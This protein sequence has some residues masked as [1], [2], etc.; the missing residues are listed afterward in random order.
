MT[1][2]VSL[3]IGGERWR[4]W[5][6]ISLQRSL[7]SFSTVT[8]TGPFDPS[9]SAMRAALRPFAFQDVTV[10]V[11]GAVVLT[12]TM[13]TPMPRGEP[14]ASSVEVSAY[15]RPAVIMDAHMPVDRFPVEW[16]GLHLAQI[17]REICDPY[18]IDLSF[19]GAPGPPFRRVKLAPD[20]APGRFLA[21][22]ARQ[23]GRVMRDTPSGSLLITESAQAGRPVA[24]LVEGEA[25]LLSAEVAFSPQD[26]FSAITGLARSKPGRL[27]AKHTQANPHLS[28]VVRPYTFATEDVD[29]GD[30]PGAVAAKLGRMFGNMVAYVAK[31]P[32]WHDSSGRLWAPDTTVSLKAPSAMVYDH[33]EFLIRDVMLEKDGDS[34]T[35]A[36]GLVLPGAFSGETPASLP[37]D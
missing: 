16:S 29:R 5:E 11:D 3:A 33:Y 28:G 25:P 36:L 23:R 31:V 18:G 27:G 9:R 22:L 4:Y 20:S 8:F 26:Y 2:E 35:A 12:G 10:A 6:Q 19:A 14:S 32:T 7:D 34:E 37:W 1:A 17:A 15:A 21:D 24:Y 30:L 13:L